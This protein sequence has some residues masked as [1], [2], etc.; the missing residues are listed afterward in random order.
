MI[1]ILYAS[2][3]SKINVEIKNINTNYQQIRKK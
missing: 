2:N 3:K 1:S